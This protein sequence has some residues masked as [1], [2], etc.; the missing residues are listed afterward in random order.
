M[1]K[2]LLGFFHGVI[3]VIER[4]ARRVT[5]VLMHCDDVNPE[6]TGQWDI[7]ECMMCNQTC[8]FSARVITLYQS[9]QKKQS[10]IDFIFHSRNQIFFY[11][12]SVHL[13]KDDLY[14]CSSTSRIFFIFFRKIS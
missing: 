13:F 12:H 10:K 5:R 4:C 6:I 14:I 11:F 7:F 1:P 8:L 3:N 9:K 2:I